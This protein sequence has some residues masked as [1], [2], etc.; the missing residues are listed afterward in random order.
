MVVWTRRRCA[1]MVGQMVQEMDTTETPPICLGIVPW[2]AVYNQEQMVSEGKGKVY[3]YES[4]ATPPGSAAAVAAARHLAPVGRA[5]CDHEG[6][7]SYERGDLEYQYLGRDDKQPYEPA[8]LAAAHKLDKSTRAKLD[9][10]HSHFLMVDNGS[11]GQNAFGSEIQMRNDIESLICAST[12]LDQDGKVADRTTERTKTHWGEIRGGRVPGAA[13]ALLHWAALVPQ[14]YVPWPAVPHVAAL[15]ARAHCSDAP[16]LPP[17][18]PTAPTLPTCPPYWRPCL[19]AR[20]QAADAD[21]AAG[22]GRRARHARHDHRDAQVGASTRASAPNPG[23]ADACSRP[24]KSGHADACSR[25]VKSG[26]ADACMQ[27][28]CEVWARGCMQPPCEVW[29]RGC[30]HAAAL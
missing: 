30:M 29:A 24:V 11:V 6:R 23:H 15:G 21:G 2:G 16:H 4:S 5:L 20:R 3:R 26:H 28:P 1:Q 18:L 27:P 17:L 8:A 22:R 25:P 7:S 19:A 12:D 14:P 10:N 9:P 13:A